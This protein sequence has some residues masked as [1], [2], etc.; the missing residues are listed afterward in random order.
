MATLANRFQFQGLFSQMFTHVSTGQDVA[1]LVDAAGATV[2]L[3]VPGVQLGDMVIGFSFGVSL[4]GMS[5]T[6]YVSA[7]DTVQIRV[8]NE[9]AGTVDLAATTVKVLVGRPSDAFFVA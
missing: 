9:S 6:A 5:V 4:A 1:S 7:A 8:Q 2:T 3:T